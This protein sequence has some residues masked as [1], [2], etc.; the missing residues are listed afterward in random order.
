VWG[1]ESP[2]SSKIFGTIENEIF[3][4]LRNF[5]ICR[6]PIQA[7]AI[8]GWTGSDLRR[9]FFLHPFVGVQTRLL[10]KRLFRF[11]MVDAAVFLQA[12]LPVNSC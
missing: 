7:G 4:C 2:D 11:E 10:R 5:I 6:M 8:P 1:A 12:R 9:V 3:F